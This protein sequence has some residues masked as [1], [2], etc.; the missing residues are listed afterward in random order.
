[1]HHVEMCVSRPTGERVDQI[2]LY[3]RE[4]LKDVQH[5]QHGDQASQQTG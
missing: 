4:E 3:L 2:L 5:E 1:M